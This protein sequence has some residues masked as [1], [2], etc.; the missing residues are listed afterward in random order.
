MV[1]TILGMQLFMGRLASCSSPQLMTESS[2]LTA[3]ER[4]AT[5]SFGS[6]DDFGSAMLMLYVMSSGDGETWVEPTRPLPPCSVMLF[7][8]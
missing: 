8:S 5:P 4:W 1:F 6:F 3:G 2:C 7:T